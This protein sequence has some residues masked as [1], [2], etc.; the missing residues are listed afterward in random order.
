MPIGITSF[1]RNLG[2]FCYIIAVACLFALL[3]VALLQWPPNGFEICAVA[4]GFFWR[5][6]WNLR[7]DDPKAADKMDKWLR[8]RAR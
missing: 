8:K 7:H 5:W 3:G 4:A 1:E 6:G 2:L